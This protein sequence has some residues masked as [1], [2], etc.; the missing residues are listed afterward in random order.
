M[1]F[2]LEWFK[3]LLIW[4]VI[5]VAVVAILQIIVPW[6]LSKMQ[7]SG[8]I[9]EGI[10]II[11]QIVR[12][13]IWAVVIIFVIYIA[14]A[15]IACLT[16]GGFS[17]FPRRPVRRDVRLASMAFALMLLAMAVA[18]WFGYDYWSTMED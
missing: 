12:I 9:A 1:C 17:L 15:L 5:V 8:I 10:G 3:D 18:S 4:L 16:G 6:V 11:S 13:V 14:F 7:A 2:Q